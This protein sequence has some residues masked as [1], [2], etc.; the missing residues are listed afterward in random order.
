MTT[1]RRLAAPLLAVAAAL[2]LGA[3]PASAQVAPSAAEAEAYAGL[4]RAAQRGDV[5]ALRQGLA[6]GEAVNGRDAHGRTPLHVATFA[7]QAEAIRALAAA[8]AD[9]GAMETDRYDAVTIAAVA[10]DLPTLSLLL[11]LGA[12]AGLVTSRYDGTALIAA[13]HLGHD[14]VVQRL[15][16]AGAPLDHVNNLHWTAAIEAVVLGDGGPRH[17]R[18]LA[19]LI[20]AGA[21]LQL[22]DRQGR[23]PLALAQARGY[24]AMVRLIEAAC[25][26]SCSEY[27]LPAESASGLAA[28]MRTSRAPTRSPPAC[29]R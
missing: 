7:R 12:S 4:F 26:T 9:L 1:R 25:S 14:T 18:T 16:R 10:D 3:A 21:N 19:A 23:T 5:A 13:A 22:A 15:I 28:C 6:R 27:R 24:T 20:D 29:S 2:A 11:D 8:G 17:Q